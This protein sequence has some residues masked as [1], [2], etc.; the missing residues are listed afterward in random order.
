MTS[1][2]LS[3][4]KPTHRSAITNGSAAL[5][6]GPNAGQA[7]P[8]ARTRIGNGKALLPDVDGRSA[9]MRRYRE[10]LCQLAND[11]GG[12]PSEAQTQIARR[13]ATLAVW[14]ESAEAAMAN[15]GSLDIAAFSTATNTLRRLLCDLGLERRLR[16]VTPS[17]HQYL[18]GKE[19]A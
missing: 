17:L 10:I 3:P 15:G 12:N 11:M 5:P 1:P 2:A 8:T 6:G 18:A 16:D 14:C 4:D 7:K 19:S 13:A 9:P